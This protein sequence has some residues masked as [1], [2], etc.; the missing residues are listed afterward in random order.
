MEMKTTYASF[1][2]TMRVNPRG[3][4]IVLSASIKKNREITW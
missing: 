4:V 2:D 3:K 1:W